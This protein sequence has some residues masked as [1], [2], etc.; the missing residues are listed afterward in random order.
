VS[1]RTIVSWDAAFND[2]ASQKWEQ[3]ETGSDEDLV[4]EYQTLELRSE[5]TGRKVH[6]E[7]TPKLSPSAPPARHAT[8][9][10]AASPLPQPKF[11]S[12]PPNVEEY[13]DF[14]N[15]DIEPRCSR[16]TW[17]HSMPSGGCAPSIDRG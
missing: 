11:M 9:A 7:G 10:L 2:L 13:L 14:D 5:P 17:A 6:T 4:V 3:E 1:R 15:D 16:P 12:P 8:P